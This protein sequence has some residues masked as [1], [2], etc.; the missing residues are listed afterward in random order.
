MFAGSGCSKMHQQVAAAFA[1]LGGDPGMSLKALKMDAAQL[2]SDV[3]F[4]DAAAS[5]GCGELAVDPGPARGVVLPL[6]S[7]EGLAGDDE[8]ALGEE[9]AV[10]ESLAEAV[11]RVLAPGAPPDP[12]VGDL[13]IRVGDRDGSKR[14]SGAGQGGGR[15][16]A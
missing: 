14:E 10:G 12:P 8:A 2:F 6:R 7:A 5:G 15:Q 9:R 3:D 4:P 13:R 11:R 16:A 1:R